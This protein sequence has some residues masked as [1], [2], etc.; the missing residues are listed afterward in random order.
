[1]LYFSIYQLAVQPD[2]MRMQ[3]Q[4]ILD[5]VMGSGPVVQIVLYLLIIFS[6][7][8]WGIILFKFRHVR[9]AKTQSAR[10]IEIFWESRNL[11]SIHEAS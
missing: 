8:S 10:F 6:V 7:V 9:E 11:A 5:L 2:H 4:G 1:M 3:Q